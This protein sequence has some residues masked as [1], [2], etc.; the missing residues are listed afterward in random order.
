MLFDPRVVFSRLAP[1]S[2]ALIGLSLPLSSVAEAAA[3]PCRP[4]AGIRVEEPGIAID[5]L[6]A[7]LKVEGEARLYVSW[8]SDLDGIAT[9]GAFESVRRV[10]GTPWAV[11]VFR[12]P[13]PVRQHLDELQKELEALAK[14]AN[15]SGERAHFQLDWRPR[16]YGFNVEDYA[17]LVKRA[18]VVV[19]GAQSDARV[20]VGPLEPS[21]NDL[22]T[23]YG[24]DTA[25]YV[26]GVALKTNGDDDVEEA[27]AL[28]RELDA[29]KP[30][31]LDRLSWPDDPSLTLSR[32]AA[33]FEQGFA[34]TLF[35][36]SRDAAALAPLKLLAREFQGDLSLDPYTVP[37]GAQKAWTFVRGE[38]LSLR[39]IAQAE[40]E[41]PQMNLFFKDGQ[42]RGPRLMSPVDGAAGTIFGQR[43]SGGGLLVPLEEP[44]RVSVVKVERMSAAELEGLEDEVLVDDSRQM[45]VEEVL[46]RLQAFEDAQTRKTDFYQ[47]RNILHL[48]FEVGTGTGGVEASF[49]GPFYFRRDQGFDWTWEDFYF[50]GVKWKGKKLPELP[51]LQPEK[52]AVLPLTINFTKE[53]TY[54]LRGT[55]MVEGRDCWVVDFEPAVEVEPGKSLY[56]G[57]VWVDREIFARVKTRSLQLGLEGEVLSNDETVFFSPVDTAGQAAPWSPDSYFLPTRVVGQQLWSLLNASIQVERESKLSN[58]SINASDFETNRQASLDSD[59]TIV[60][61][62]DKGLRYLVK[63]ESGKRVVQEEFDTKRL[64]LAGGVFYDEGQDFPIPLAGVNYLDLDFRDSGGQLNVLFAGPFLTA[65]VAQPRLMG[66]KWDLGANVNGIFINTGSEL[67]RDGEEVAAE[68]VESRQAS[69]N[70]FLGRQLGNFTKVDFSFGLS[71]INFGSADDTDP[72]FIIPEDTLVQ[73]LGLD[74][75]YSRSGYRFRVS[76]SLNERQDWEFW[77]LPDNTEFNAEQEDFL[78]WQVS[79]GKTWWLP[80]FTKFGIELEHLNGEDLDRFSKYDFGLFGDG[81][82][83]GY[84]NGLVVA[85]EA[86]GVHLTYGIGLSDLLQVEIEGD[87]VWATDEDTGLDNELLAGIGL[88]GTIMGPWETILN[89]ELGVPVAG[90]GEG[91]SARLVFLKLFDNWENWFKKKDKD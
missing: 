10:G 30:V 40:P 37:T 74:I 3:P 65:N 53:Y 58:I 27:I 32:T 26:D 69:V 17:Y 22:R 82:V 14:L 48:R 36:F 90:P 66:S 67:Y 77:G 88:E 13:A 5:A 52:A 55:E 54:R 35:D 78:K 49:D 50:N 57:T 46:R 87:A 9:N 59:K 41:A 71:S 70:V 85:S 83:A 80:N 38:D 2:L 34:V 68:E 51:I 56:Q 12:T 76:G 21:L 60:R 24:E 47:A 28:L 8:E 23:F 86:N 89:F 73:E 84:Q 62:T 43:R 45:P 75:T 91:F 63:D 44:S 33:A 29:G 61:D 6:A 64:F 4:C 42:L 18:A 19:T 25:A 7:G 31:V 79:L 81:S 16:G 15:G 1:L 20:I 39:V 11:T 72:D